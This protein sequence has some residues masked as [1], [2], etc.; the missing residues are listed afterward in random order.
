MKHS[1]FNTVV[2]KI[3]NLLIY[4][5]LSGALLKIPKNK[6]KE[7]ENI[8]CKEGFL[9]EDDKDELLTYKYIYYKKLFENSGLHL[10]IA[11]TTDCNLC[12][13][14]CFEEGNKHKEY[15]D[16]EV[17]DSIIKYI[18]SKKDKNIHITWFGGEPLLCFNRIVDLSN[19]LADNNVHFRASMITNGTLFSDNIIDKLPSLNLSSIQITLDGERLEH[20]QKRFFKNKMGT[21]DVILSNVTKL[22][23][24][25][26]IHVVLKINIDKDNINSYLELVG[27]LTTK[28]DKYITTNQLTILNNSVKNRT[29][30]KGCTKC[31]SEDEYFEFRTK[32]L[33]ENIPI[34]HLH[35]SCPLRHSGNLMIGPDGNIYKCLEHIGD[36]SQSIGNIKNYSISISKMAK[37][38]LSND[39]FDDIE[40]SNCAILPI[41]GGGCPIDR[42]SKASGKS[43]SLCPFIKANLSTI[44]GKACNNQENN[45]I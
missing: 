41:C 7:Y 29:D 27:S 21:F 11:P 26:S 28:Y 22:L 12:C 30:F 9:V 20:N 15:M 40:C 14:Y 31:L 3:D 1:K 19:N 37:L 23:E 42:A 8:L 43:I 17:S 32:V 16:Q 18:I 39:P 33:H 4:N 38:A 2:E 45:G 24:N 25:T 5:S 13:P 34:P 10:T 36:K 35:L 44:I 6:I